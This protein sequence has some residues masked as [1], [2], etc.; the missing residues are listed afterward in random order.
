MR[1]NIQ[2]NEGCQSD[3]IMSVSDLPPNSPQPRLCHLVKREDFNGY[4]FNLHAEKSKPGQYIGTVDQGSPAEL[5]GLQ[6]GDRIV[7][8]NG[9][10]ISQ[11]NHKQVVERIKSMSEETKL[12]VVDR[13]TEELYKKFT[14]VVK[15]SLPTVLYQSSAPNFDDDE[16][17]INY[18]I[19]EAVDPPPLPMTP[20]PNE[21]D[22]DKNSL[23]SSSVDK[24]RLIVK[25]RS[26][27]A[28]THMFLFLKH[29][30][31][32]FICHFRPR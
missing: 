28:E 29:L 9:I 20:P 31:Y 12:L 7:E 32:R 2:F 23:G 30:F 13:E 10:N 14:I 22:E 18:D 3:I 5:A 17:Q 26:L 1:E 11:E 4:G 15:G 27:F 16:Q 24:V 19:Q 8:V 6:E 21:G 25:L